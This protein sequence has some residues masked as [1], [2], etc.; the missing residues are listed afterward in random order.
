M[1]NVLFPK[2]YC[3]KALKTKAFVLGCDPTAFDKDGKRIEFEYVFGIGKDKRYFAGINSNLV[4]LGL[5]RESVYVQNLVTDYHEK[6]T[7]KNDKWPSIA[8]QYI[9]ERKAE[10][11]N[12]D[13]SNKIPVFLTSDLLYKV[14]LNEGETLLSPADLYNS[15]NAYFIHA[16]NNKLSRPLIPLYRHSAYSLKK[17]AKF[18]DR[19]IKYF[20]F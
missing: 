4:E 3:N 7:A 19:V 15:E 6:E 12:I 8:R 11:D 10:F 14:L 13:P 16:E 20:K 5:S 17:Q 2:H 18:V 9:S 1:T